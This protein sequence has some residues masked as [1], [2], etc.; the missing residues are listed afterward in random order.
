MLSKITLQ[1]RVFGGSGAIRTPVPL[2]GQDVFKT[3]LVRPLEYT[4]NKISTYCFALNLAV[5]DF[6]PT[7]RNALN[8]L[9][10]HSTAPLLSLNNISDSYVSGESRRDIG[11]PICI[12][13]N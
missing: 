3:S 11:I 7:G 10:G 2:A 5:G 6:K 8:L 1:L 9:A 12:N 13:I 4:S